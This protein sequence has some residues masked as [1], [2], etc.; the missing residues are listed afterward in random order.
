M[1]QKRIPIWIL[2]TSRIIY[3]TIT[4]YWYETSIP[5]LDIHTSHNLH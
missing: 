3:I 5:Y 2:Y 4:R 1:S